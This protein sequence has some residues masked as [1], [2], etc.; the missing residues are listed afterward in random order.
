MIDGSS[1]PDALPPRSRSRLWVAGLV[2]LALLLVAPPAT[3]GPADPAQDYPHLPNPSCVTGDQRVPQH[4][5]VCHLTP[6]QKKRPTV[7]L[8]GDSHAWMLTPA[9]VEAAKVDPVNP[10]VFTLGACPPLLVAAPDPGERFGSKCEKQNYNALKYVL[11]LKRADRPVR[12]LFAAN[13]VGYRQLWRETEGGTVPTDCNG[14]PNCDYAVEMA[15]L[16]HKGTPQIFRKLGDLGVEVDVVGQMLT[17]PQPRPA[18]ACRFKEVYDCPIPRDQAIPDEQET[19][20]WVDLQMGKL[21]HGPR[22][23]RYIDM[24]SKVCDA[25]LCYG[26]KNSIYTFFD[27]LHLSATRSATLA[28]RLAKTLQFGT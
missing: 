16:S 13:W 22:R 21:A 26:K 1:A 3:A 28:P 14:R 11:D 6:F 23:P 19:R 27:D 20:D 9:L 8:W 2:A 10:D 7:V 17:V 4:A 5:V 15:V 18:T 12:V 24:N 25:K